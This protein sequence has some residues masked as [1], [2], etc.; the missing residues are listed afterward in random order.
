MSESCSGSQAVNELSMSSEQLRLHKAVLKKAFQREQALR[1]SLEEKLSA[2]D[3]EIA[4]LTAEVQRLRS[5][6]CVGAS[7]ENVS[8]EE[9]T[10]F[11]S[12]L[13]GDENFGAEAV[14]VF[15]WHACYLCTADIGAW[16]QWWLAPADESII[17]PLLRQVRHSILGV[18]RQSILGICLQ[19]MA[20]SVR[21]SK[22]MLTPDSAVNA[23]G[24][25]GQRRARS[26]HPPAPPCWT[27]GFP[28][29]N[30]LQ[31]DFRRWRRRPRK[32]GGRRRR[33]DGR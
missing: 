2:R 17:A 6:T 13:D 33:R 5:A 4:S 7:A 16:R 1:I 10:P 26:R 12:N 18:R 29:H 24:G 32:R 22:S 14:G 3:I 31:R 11:S 28:R 20:A 19:R 27:A 21:G 8:L 9:F 25:L 23:A 30:L 15:V